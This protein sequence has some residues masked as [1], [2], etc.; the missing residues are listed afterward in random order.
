VP[1]GENESGT[2]D[3]RYG[4]R[5]RLI[6]H[7]NTHG[8]EN[9]VTLTGIRY[10]MG[11]GDAALAMQLVAR[12]LDADP[13]S[14]DTENLPISGGDFG[15]FESL[16]NT[17]KAAAQTDLDPAALRALAHN[18]GT[19]ALSLLKDPDAT[20]QV[21]LPGSHV[22]R[23]EV[24]NAVRNEMALTLADVVLR[25]TDLGTGGNPGRAALVECAALAAGE[26]SWSPA[27]TERQIAAVEAQFP[28]LN[29]AIVASNSS[30]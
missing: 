27:E 21:T 12:K 24:V 26:L 3:L 5:S 7:A 14:P 25:R 6:D 4:K 10:T 2:T 11:R 28:V 1:F 23:A 13:T 30:A 20:L 22:L 18:H 9:L 17:L 29:P 19:S 8:I 16:I 15:N